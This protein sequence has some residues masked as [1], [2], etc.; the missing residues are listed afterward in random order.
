MTSV[1]FSISVIAKQNAMCAQVRVTGKGKSPCLG[2][3]MYLFTMITAAERTI[4]THRCLQGDEHGVAAQSCL[5]CDM[6]ACTLPTYK[7]IS[8]LC[9]GCHALLFSLS[10]AS[11]GSVICNNVHNYVLNAIMCLNH[12]IN[13]QII[14]NYLRH[15][16]KVQSAAEDSLRAHVRTSA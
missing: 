7:V 4:Q 2:S 10:N 5:P 9:P 3:S 15:T 6:Q 14:M 8:W 16:Y 11:L 1:H 13:V 12:K